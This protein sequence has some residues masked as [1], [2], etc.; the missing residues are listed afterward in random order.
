MKLGSLLF[1]FVKL[2][3]LGPNDNL[4]DRIE[5]IFM[6]DLNKQLSKSLDK[7]TYLLTLFFLK[8]I[9]KDVILNLFT[10]KHLENDLLY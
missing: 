2:L 8:D 4:K 1:S 5:Y 10:L 3:I 9:K 6:N 7:Y